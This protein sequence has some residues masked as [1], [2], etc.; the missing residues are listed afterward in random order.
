MAQV[1]TFEASHWTAKQHF[2]QTATG[3]LYKMKKHGTSRSFMIND[4]FVLFFHYRCLLH[5]CSRTMKRTEVP[6]RL[7]ERYPLPAGDLSI[8][9]TSDMTLQAVQCTM[10]GWKH[11]RRLSS[12]GTDWRLN[13]T[14]Q[15]VPEEYCISNRDHAQLVGGEG[16]LVDGLTMADEHLHTEN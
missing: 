10:T 16:H 9:C 5:C 4:C 7:A 13:R 14:G 12:P 11:W 8:E 1:P 15:E 3:L 6:G 2:G